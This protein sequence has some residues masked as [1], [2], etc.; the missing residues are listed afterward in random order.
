LPEEFFE[1]L[2]V[3]GLFQGEALLF[4]VNAAGDEVAAAES[5]DIGEELADLA[6]FGFGIV[7]E[8]RVVSGGGEAERNPMD[9]VVDQGGRRQCWPGAG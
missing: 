8:G 2:L 4:E 6:Q 9:E 3:F 7:G 5:D 1:G